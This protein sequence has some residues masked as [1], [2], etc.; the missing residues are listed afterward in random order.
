MTMISYNIYKK[1]KFFQKYKN[2]SPAFTPKP[3]DFYTLGFYTV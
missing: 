1:V 2:Y 3:S